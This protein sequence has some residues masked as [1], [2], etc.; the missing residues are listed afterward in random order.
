MMTIYSKDVEFFLNC[1]STDLDEISEIWDQSGGFIPM[2][3]LVRAIVS[4]KPYSESA[5]RLMMQIADRSFPKDFRSGA[6]ERQNFFYGLA[7]YYAETSTEPM[8]LVEFDVGNC[9]GTGDYAGDEAVLQVIRFMRKTFEDTLAKHGATYVEAFDN[10]KNDDLKLIV[11]GLDSQQLTEAISDAQSEILKTFIIGHSIPHSKYDDR[12]GIGVGSGFVRLG[13]GKD[14]QK[15]QERLNLFIETRKLED[16]NKRAQ[17]AKKVDT[18]MIQTDFVRGF[19]S[20]VFQD[21]GCS[22]TDL[23]NDFPFAL[24]AVSDISNPFVARERVCEMLAKEH[25]LT[26]AECAEFA[27]MI[28]FYH[29]SEALTGAQK[30]PFLFGDI[31]WVRDH[32][33]DPVTILN[34]KV[35]NCAGVNKVLSHIHSAEM[36]KHFAQIVSEFTERNFDEE[37]ASLIYYTGR[38]TFNVIIPKHA[39]DGVE[40]IFRHY[41]Q[42]EIDRQIN[43]RQCGEYFGSMGLD[44]P[45]HMRDA[46]VGDIKNL[47]GMDPGVL[48]INIHAI[49]SR[50]ITTEAEILDFQNQCLSDK[51]IGLSSAP[52][53]LPDGQTYQDLADGLNAS[54]LLLV[55]QRMASRVVEQDNLEELGP[56]ADRLNARKLK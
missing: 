9:N 5:K 56:L 18:S 21:V 4:R 44:V 48:A 23:D 53:V 8:A 12:S 3:D 46:K 38:N 43:D 36:T 33:G 7:D 45:D 54:E 1:F 47:R 13:R 34:L 41:L 26:P 25:G 52:L 39:P 19:L 31:A 20:T 35:E 37:C 51:R 16:S 14:P 2:P 10:A 40:R 55:L 24:D 29:S 22:E 11:T 15:L 30:S 50:E 6:F 49:D 32:S 42:D 27:K 28:E 17:I